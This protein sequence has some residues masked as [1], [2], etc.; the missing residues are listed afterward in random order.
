MTRRLTAALFGFFLA[1]LVPLLVRTDQADRTP[2]IASQLNDGA[3][4]DVLLFI[5]DG[6]GDSEITAARN[7]YA[8]A[9][10]RLALD[11]LPFSR[12]PSAGTPPHPN[13]RVLDGVG[14]HPAPRPPTPRR[15]LPARRTPEPGY[16]RELAMPRVVPADQLCEL[17]LMSSLR[18]HSEDRTPSAAPGGRPLGT[19]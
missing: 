13:V 19:E 8:G 3:A 17:P 10:G 15:I 18:G 16:L 5:G 7:Y 9:G 1:L 2:Q 11:T 4:R 14:R 12:G 6:M